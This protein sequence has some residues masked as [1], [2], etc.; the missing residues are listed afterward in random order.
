MPQLTLST[1]LCTMFFFQTGL[2]YLKTTNSIATWDHKLR[3][4]TTLQIRLNTGPSSGQKINLPRTN[5]NC[6]IQIARASKQAK[7]DE[8]TN[9]QW[10]HLVQPQIVSNCS[11]NNT[12]LSSIVTLGF[13][14]THLNKTD[15]KNKCFNLRGERSCKTT[16]RTD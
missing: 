4:N 13:H 15:S 1:L 11:N 14:F 7:Y 2:F 12:N 3:L 9:L 8:Q 16:I 6:I 10:W 5:S